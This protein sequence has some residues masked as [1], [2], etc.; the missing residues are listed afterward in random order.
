MPDA[1]TSAAP[2]Y[3]GRPSPLT[4]SKKAAIL[5]L[6]LDQEAAALMLK[7]LGETQV[8]EV[9]RELAATGS[10]KKEVRDQVLQEF[11]DLAVGA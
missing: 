10:I 3:E 1:S 2:P 7:Q 6:A 8:E 11:Y 5:L 9:T 4:G